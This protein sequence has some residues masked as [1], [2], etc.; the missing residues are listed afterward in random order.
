ML[1]LHLTMTLM[2]YRISVMKNKG[3]KFILDEICALVEMN[4]RKVRFYIQKGLVDRPEGTGKGAFYT[5]THLEQLL[6]IRKWKGAGLTLERIQE[7]L[8]S[9]KDAYQS[10]R[11]LPP[12]ILK[13]QG[14]VEVWSH[15]NV[16]DGIELHIEPKRAGLSPD[17][18]RVLFREVMNLYKKIREEGPKNV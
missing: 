9:E 2:V 18:V 15:M 4:K 13:K 16:D 1:Y 12:P 6:A 3:Q 17:Q 7:I 11:P 10:D 8:G 14:S 5:H